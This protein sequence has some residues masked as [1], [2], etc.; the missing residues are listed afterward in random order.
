MAQN[1][2]PLNKIGAYL[3]MSASGIEVDVLDDLSVVGKPGG[4]NDAGDGYMA[5]DALGACVADA[6]SKGWKGGIMSWEYPRADSAW[7]A[8]AKGGAL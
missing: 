8:A 7:I 6:V 4:P 5:P 2:I 3:V 1:G